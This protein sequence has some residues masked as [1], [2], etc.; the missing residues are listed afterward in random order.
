MKP[1]P[2]I[3]EPF[4]EVIIDCVGP[5]PKSK[6]GKQYLL[7]IMCRN[8]RYPEAFPLRTIK[9]KQII[10]CLNKFFLT[11]SYPRVI[12]SDN[13]SNFVSKEFQAYVQRHNIK[14]VCSSPYHPESQGALE[15]YHQTLKTMLRKYCHD[16]TKN[17]E[18]LLPF[19]LFCTRDTI[20]ASLGFSPFQLIYGHEVRGPLAL[21]KH[22]CV[23]GK[24]PVSILSHVE[25]FTS[26]LRECRAIAERNICEAQGKMKRW[27]DRDCV[28][29]KFKVGDK[30][31][32]FLPIEKGSLEAKFSGPYRIIEKVGPLT[33][34]IETPDRGRA[35]RT[36]HVNQLK[37][38]YDREEE[39]P[40]LQVSSDLK[41]DDDEEGFIAPRLKN[42][43][44]LAEMGKYLQDVPS[45][46]RERL[47]P[48]FAEFHNLFSDTPGRTNK[49]MHDVCLT[50]TTPVRSKPYRYNPVK[51]EIVR[52]EVRY[53]L[54]N[55]LAVPSSSEW[56]SPCFLVKKPDGSHRL[57]CDF[58]KVNAQIK[59]D[60]FPMPRLM[61][62]VDQV[63]KATYISKIDLLKGYWQVPLTPLAQEVYSFATS[64]G[65]FSFNV[66]P[67][68]SK[69][70]PACFQRLMS[71]VL[72]G[73]KGV[74]CYLDDII[75]FEESFN[76][77]LKQVRQVFEAL[78]K[79]SLVVN[80]AKSEFI[81]SKVVYL[82]HTV[83]HGN[84]APTTA[85][86]DAIL[87]LQPP[88]DVRGV[89]RF[90]GAVGFYRR[91]CKN[92]SEV[93]DPLT[94]LL[95]KGQG[96]KW[97]P[98]CQ[99]SFEDLKGMLSCSP[100]LKAPEFSKPF[101]LF[102][103]ASYIAVGATLMQEDDNSFLR[104]VAYFSRKLKSHQANYSVIELECLAIVDALKHFEI[105]L[106]GKFQTV[107][108]SDHNPLSFLQANKQKNRK[109][110]RWS[111]LIDSY[112]V[113]IQHVSGKQNRIADLL[114]RAD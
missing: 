83:G 98:E 30:C 103:D 68:G 74:A 100:I 6:S 8:T 84:I 21:L 72:R 93:S 107:V 1:I 114:S 2:C 113:N 89:R 111:I 26:K 40:V 42:S 66:V 87:R 52:E 104:P 102:C 44:I 34:K 81:K 63:G 19:L 86:I 5:L 15:R 92:F 78:R 82:G 31:L 99:Q 9:A 10:D 76:A 12:Q 109:L 65:L 41:E 70:S 69:N 36:C 62:C 4:S 96:F 24:S 94:N 58:R 80:L 17:W 106:S 32:V 27:Y 18:E 28:T 59:F 112:N 45:E 79:A 60:A 35:W 67:F 49:T 85:N 14:H 38:Y 43:S 25:E 46:E 61:D 108:Y 29:R 55:G 11:V 54:D 77:H 47:E 7:T 97:T 13:G 16:N 64:D 90:L 88:K 37:E 73:I 23:D 105:Y 75:V 110:Y 56:A 48:L 51:E 53:L 71:K 95:R 57:V 101:V 3:G 39:T 20:Q 33:Y 91:F 22:N 50:D